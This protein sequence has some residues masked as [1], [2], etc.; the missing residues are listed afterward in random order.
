M[1]AASLLKVRICCCGWMA[2]SSLSLETSI[3]TNGP[4][5]AGTADEVEG[6][7]EATDVTN[8]LSCLCELDGVR[9]S[10]VCSGCWTR[11]RLEPCFATASRCLGAV[12]FGPTAAS[13]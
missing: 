11:R 3:P 5:A 10:F 7:T 12:G 2:R 13:V 9:G 4:E 6:T 1:P 8:T